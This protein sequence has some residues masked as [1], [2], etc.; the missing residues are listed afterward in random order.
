MSLV[1]LIMTAEAARVHTAVRRTA[2]RHQHVAARPLVVVAYNLSGEAA[3]PLGIMYGCDA[4]DP[5]VVVAAEPRNR[6]SRFGAINE[7]AAD[8]AKFIRPYLELRTERTKMGTFRQVAADAPQIVV[9]NSSTRAYL[10]AR[11]GRSLRY[12]GLGSTHEVPEDTQWAGAHL[13][14]FAEHS[15]LPGQSTFLAMTESLSQ[16]FVTGQSALEDESLAAL[17]A[18]IDGVPGDLLAEL[19]RLENSEGQVGGQLPFGPVPHPRW[20]ARLEPYVKAYS[21]GLREMDEEKTSSA[22]KKVAAEVESALLPAYNATH[23]ALEVLRYIDEA[24]SVAKRW[25]KDVNEWSDHARRAGNG[26]P[27]FA[28]RHDPL[29]AA[30]TLQRWSSAADALETDQAFD[31]PL[32]MARLDAQGRCVTGEVAE[33]D[34]QNREVKPG[35]KNRTRVPLIEL[36]LT[37]PTR[38]LPGEVVRWTEERTIKGI[39]RAVG[40]STATIAI[41]GGIKKFDAASWATRRE[42]I[43][44]G[45]DPWEGS[46]PWTPNEVPWTHQTTSQLAGEADSAAGT[47]DDSPDMSLAELAKVP[48]VGEVGPDAEPGVLQ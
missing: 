39:V 32:I 36:D 34:S 27:R 33:I 18:W 28:R 20:E 26:I 40:E 12:L 22:A 45:L 47:S 37:G 2:Y 30:A 3:A 42:V 13:S 35:G 31:D 16:H 15:H 48:V 9:P 6:E 10:G 41:T 24:A 21:D 17:L 38:L 19:E 5:K 46:D 14:W 7:F 25:T 11:L 23:R 1:D 29:R 43:F 8:F 44:V 4:N